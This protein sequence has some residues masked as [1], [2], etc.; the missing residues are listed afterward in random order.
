MQSVSLPLQV[1]EL[2]GHLGCLPW[3]DGFDGDCCLLCMFDETIETI[4][5]LVGGTFLGAFIKMQVKLDPVS[6]LVDLFHSLTGPS[7][8]V[9]LIPLHQNWKMFS[10]FTVSHVNWSA[11]SSCVMV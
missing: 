5:L 10:S 2:C 8:L 11:I 4:G 9:V 7:G 1:L 3:V 6:F